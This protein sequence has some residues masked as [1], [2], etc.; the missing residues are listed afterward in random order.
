MYSIRND[1]FN[2]KNIHQLVAGGVITVVRSKWPNSK[3]A[4][5]KT[6]QLKNSPGSN[7]FCHL[8]LAVGPLDPD[9]EKLI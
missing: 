4:W 5:V 3:T 8:H 2:E 6:I 1:S 7:L 9:S